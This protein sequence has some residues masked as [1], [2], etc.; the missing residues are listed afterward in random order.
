MAVALQE[1]LLVGAIRCAVMQQTC[2]FFV[3]VLVVLWCQ[4][5]IITDVKV[6]K[7]VAM[8]PVSH[9]VAPVLT[10]SHECVIAKTTFWAMKM[11]I[12]PTSCF[13]RRMFLQQTQQHTSLLFRQSIVGLLIGLTRLPTLNVSKQ[14]EWRL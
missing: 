8:A 14:D 4:R 9:E 7:P 10:V 5:I 13:R 1:C 11:P 12:P 2:S 3:H 6:V